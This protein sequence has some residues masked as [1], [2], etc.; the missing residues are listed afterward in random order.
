VGTIDLQIEDLL[1]DAE[2]PR[3]VRGSSQRD[4]NRTLPQTL[5]IVQL[6]PHS[7]PATISIRITN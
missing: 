1:L 7:V 5:P 3:F 2:N 4:T 6:E